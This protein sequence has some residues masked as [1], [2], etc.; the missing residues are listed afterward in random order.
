MSRKEEEVIKESIS[1]DNVEKQEGLS[2]SRKASETHEKGEPS[3][4]EKEGS[5]VSEVRE[6]RRKELDEQA[7]L[8]GTQ[9]DNVNEEGER[10]VGGSTNQDNQEKE[11]HESSKETKGSSSGSERGVVV[12]KRCRKAGEDKVSTSQH[13]KP[14]SQYHTSVTQRTRTLANNKK[15]QAAYQERIQK[16]RLQAL[17]ETDRRKVSSSPARKFSTVKPIAAT[18]PRTVA[19][20]KH[21]KQVEDFA[22]LRREE[23][24]KKKEVEAEV[25][26]VP[27]Q[28]TTET[29]T[30][31]DLP[32]VTP[33]TI[34]QHYDDFNAERLNQIKQEKRGTPSRQAVTV[35]PV[36]D[37][38]VTTPSPSI[39]ESTTE[40]DTE[41][42]RTTTA[43]KQ[44]SVDADTSNTDEARVVGE[45]IVQQKPSQVFREQLQPTVTWTTM[46]VT[47]EKRQVTI[48][49]VASRDLS[50]TSPA[51]STQ[52]SEQ[53]DSDSNTDL[54]VP[55]AERLQLKT[56]KK[57]ALQRPATPTVSKKQRKR[58]RLP[59]PNVD[60]DAPRSK[61]QCAIAAQEK[62]KT[63]LAM[64]AEVEST[65]ESGEEMQDV[66]VEVEEEDTSDIE[67]TLVTKAGK[68][69]YEAREGV[70]NRSIRKST[71]VVTNYVKPKYVVSWKT[72][73][74]AESQ[75]NGRWVHRT[76]TGLQ[77]IR[78]DIHLY[79]VKQ[80]FE[81]GL[82]ICSYTHR[83]EICDTL[84]DSTDVRKFFD[85]Y[86]LAARKI[87]DKNDAW[88]SHPAYDHLLPVAKRQGSKE[89][90][91]RVVYN[92]KSPVR[93]DVDNAV[94][95]TAYKAEM[96]EKL[97]PGEEPFNPI[98]PVKSSTTTAADTNETEAPVSPQPDV[99][100]TKD[101]E[102]GTS[103]RATAR[104]STGL[105]RKRRSSDVQKAKDVES[106]LVQAAVAEGIEAT[107]PI[108]KKNMLAWITPAL[109]SLQY[110]NC[111]LKLP[112]LTRNTIWTQNIK[113]RDYLPY[114]KQEFMSSL[115]PSFSE[116]IHKDRPIKYRSELARRRHQQERKERKRLDKIIRRAY[117]DGPMIDIDEERLAKVVE[118]RLQLVTAASLDPLLSRERISEIVKDD[119][120][121]QE[122]KKW[123]EK[124][125]EEIKLAEKEKAKEDK[126]R[127]EKEEEEEKRKEDL[128]LNLEIDEDYLMKT[129]ELTK[130]KLYIELDTLIAQKIAEGQQEIPTRKELIISF[131]KHLVRADTVDAEGKEKEKQQE[132]EKE[133][134]QKKKE[135]ERRRYDLGL[136]I[137]INEELLDGSTIES[138]YDRLD[139]RMKRAK[140]PSNKP[141]PTRRML[142]ISAIESLEKQL[143]R[144]KQEIEEKLKKKEEEERE[145]RKHDHDYDMGMDIALDAEMLD[146]MTE[147]EFHQK[148]DGVI[149]HR[150]WPEDK[151]PPTRREIIFNLIAFRTKKLEDKRRA[152]EEELIRQQELEEA[153]ERNMTRIKTEQ[154]E[155]MAQSLQGRRQEEQERMI[156]VEIIREQDERQLI[157]KQEL[158]QRMEEENRIVDEI[159]TEKEVREKE[160]REEWEKRDAEEKRRMEQVMSELRKAE[161]TEANVT[162]R[163][164][165]EV[166]TMDQEE[167]KELEKRLTEQE[168]IWE[169]A[170][171]GL[172]T[173][174]SA[175]EEDIDQNNNSS[176][177]EGEEMIDVEGKPEQEK[178]HSVVQ[179]N[180]QH[181]MTTGSGVEEMTASSQATCMPGPEHTERPRRHSTR[182][183]QQTSGA[184]TPSL[185][186]RVPTPSSKADVYSEARF[187]AA[188]TKLLAIRKLI[189][190]DK[191][192]SIPQDLLP[193]HSSIKKLTTLEAYWTRIMTL[194][195][196]KQKQIHDQEIKVKI[197]TIDTQCYGCSGYAD[198]IIKA[199]DRQEQ[200]ESIPMTPHSEDGAT[201]SVAQLSSALRAINPLTSI[202]T[203]ELRLTSKECGEYFIKRLLEE[204]RHLIGTVLMNEHVLKP[205][206]VQ[207]MEEI[208]EMFSTVP[209][210]D[211]D[212]LKEAT[213]QEYLDEIK[214]RGREPEEIDTDGPGS[215]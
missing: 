57:L 18:P 24:R 153:S 17:E 143:E 66:E 137:V 193:R 74:K 51:P 84:D 145:A 205:E 144:K 75:A 192:Q 71:R 164:A 170:M 199:L 215:P 7:V 139:K 108:G 62:V 80:R 53:E 111:E 73:L 189:K 21:D 159:L 152:I 27:E 129:A 166:G 92:K 89:D 5:K 70:M 45:V 15:L 100:P 41:V 197:G 201:P 116:T 107:G 43:I 160:S 154:E 136:D 93:K 132:R 23:A 50:L 102:G 151:P 131:M 114:T 55:L 156:H 103:R 133:E 65:G 48:R 38:P 47:G 72:T 91:G 202:P 142:I 125:R 198:P 86:V 87:L 35:T 14:R 34:F 188:S 147:E 25:R 181:D 83:C 46:T 210:C 204:C 105:K 163:T 33:N 184:S 2:I 211:L 4:S 98:S 77:G 30:D 208:Q 22:R 158:E 99:V 113:T 63:A 171:Q 123:M 10:D 109:A 115:R 214:K 101:E 161:N 207:K 190:E 195:E 69:G 59:L 187:I 122:E 150:L 3:K 68:I 127:Q 37:Q 172:E 185:K 140:W 56:A 20:R 12:K 149:A 36:L 212:R 121:K 183:S 11:D 6:G 32:G 162:G 96:S 178:E 173:G 78:G 155:A 182:S 79:T 88:K 118:Q 16:R 106:D 60:M 169:E 165:G 146:G 194:E 64:K 126:K 82:P 120:M 97:K 175:E 130:E 40:S 110:N 196:N 203:E 157:I 174:E 168:E 1:Q 135:E 29:P 54:R 186:S 191:N 76:K 95:S 85:A 52:V 180:K 81:F 134:E 176:I 128:G 94:F 42:P 200:F 124:R 8:P 28:N 138:F 119:M 104:M 167:R 177:D 209:A 206:T 39:R 117:P 148:V 9:V 26:A 49:P 179:T 67:E 31:D 58:S 90:K 141:P 19:E 112:I 213:E 44:E 13:K 61:R